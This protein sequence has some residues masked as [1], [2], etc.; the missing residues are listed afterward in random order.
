MWQLKRSL[1]AIS[2]GLTELKSLKATASHSVLRTKFSVALCSAS[3]GTTQHTALLKGW[4][5]VIKPYFL[6]APMCPTSSERVT[7]MSQSQVCPVNVLGLIFSCF[8][9]AYQAWGI[10][11]IYR[12]GVW[13]VQ[14]LKHLTL[15]YGSGHHLTICESEPH[16]RLYADSVE[17]VWVSLSLSLS[18]PPHPPHSLNK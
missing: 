11:R 2:M 18:A 5:Q 6:S 12:R 9:T 4:I 3:T 7:G 17:T 14:F 1:H 15:D 13:V 8:F 10:Q 16:I